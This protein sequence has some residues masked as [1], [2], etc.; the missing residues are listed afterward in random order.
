[1]LPVADIFDLTVQTRRIL[2]LAL[3]RQTKFFS[4]PVVAYHDTTPGNRGVYR[5]T[6]VDIEATTDVGG[7]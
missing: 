6:G 4:P 5:E 3:S 1:M 7:G 2:H